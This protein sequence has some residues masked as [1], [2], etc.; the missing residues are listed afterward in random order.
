MQNLNKMS[1][2]KLSLLSELIIK[3]GKSNTY[4]RLLCVL[5]FISVGLILQSSFYFS[6]KLIL[7]IAIL[8]Q[9]SFDYRRKSPC[10]EIKEIQF[11]QDKQIG[12]MTKTGQQSYTEVLILIHNMLFQLIVFSNFNK[13]KIIILFNDQ[14][15]IAQL[16]LLHL[17]TATK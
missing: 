10:S 16:R 14:I 9:L 12:I 5:Y 4:I 6:I 15:P 2:K 1:L 17:K 11:F 13:R 7:I 3:P 8:I